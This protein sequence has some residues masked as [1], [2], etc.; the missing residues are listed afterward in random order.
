MVSSSSTR[1]PLRKTTFVLQFSSC[2]QAT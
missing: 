1:R 2:G